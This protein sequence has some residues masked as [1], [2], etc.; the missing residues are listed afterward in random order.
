MTSLDEFKLLYE[1]D[2]G[3]PDFLSDSNQ[4]KI[5]NGYNISDPVNAAEVLLGIFPA[6]SQV[7]GSNQDAAPY[8]DIRKVTFTFKDNSKVVVTM[9]NQFGQGW[10]PQDWTDGSGVRSRTAADLAQ[11]YARAVLHKS[12]QYIFPILT[13]DGQKD[14]ITQQMAMTGGEQWTW[15]YG[16]SSPSATDF[17]LLPTDDEQ[18]YTVVFRY[19]RSAQY[20]VRLAYPVQTIREN[21]NSQVLVHIS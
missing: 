20:D 17:V 15:K 1:N 9:I 16:P 6:A 21:K 10:L 8:N 2:L 4:W 3:L 11:Q 12:A 5:T 7:E 13:P 18:D 19:T 14:L